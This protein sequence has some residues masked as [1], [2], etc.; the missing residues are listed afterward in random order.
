MLGEDIATYIY[1]VRLADLHPELSHPSKAQMSLSLIFKTAIFALL[2][3][4]FIGN[5]IQLWL[6]ILLFAL[7]KIFALTVAPLL[8]KSKLIFRS[9]PKGALKIVIMVFVGTIFGRWVQ[10]QYQD[11]EQFVKWG[12]VFLG[13]PGLLLQFVSFFADRS[14]TVNW[15]VVGVGRFIYRIG[16]VL[17]FFLVV[18]MS[19]GKNLVDLVIGK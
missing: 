2:A 5:S 10:S 17:I 9:I 8:P 13:L 11:P 12:F 4:P 18:E 19:L 7:P 15:K 3:E 1:P 14:T 16:G 6:G